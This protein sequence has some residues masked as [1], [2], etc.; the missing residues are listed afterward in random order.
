MELALAVTGGRAGCCCLVTVAPPIA[1]VAD[2]ETV[3]M[4][5][6]FEQQ[7]RVNRD[8]LQ[9]ETI[10][11]RTGLAKT[12]DIGRVETQPER[13]VAAA[14]AVAVAE[15]PAPRPTRSLVPA[16]RQE[17]G[18]LFAKMRLYRIGE[19]MSVTF[20]SWKVA[21]TFAQRKATM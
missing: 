16:P 4:K 10:P 7:S 5:Q 13:E 2:I 12:P 18:R 17:Y 15:E 20:R 11:M 9:R 14:T 8:G 19:S 21:L 6:E 3:T 1:A